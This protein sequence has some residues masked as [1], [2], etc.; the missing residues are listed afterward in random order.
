VKTVGE[1][2]INS[3]SASFDGLDLVSLSESLDGLDLQNPELQWPP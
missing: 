1:A 2:R 3:L